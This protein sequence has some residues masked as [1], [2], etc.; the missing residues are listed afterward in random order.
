M[1]VAVGQLDSNRYTNRAADRVN[2]WLAAYNPN[3]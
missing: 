2:E 3:N 1:L